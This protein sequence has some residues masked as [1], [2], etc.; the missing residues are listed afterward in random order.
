MPLNRLYVSIQDVGRCVRRYFVLV[1][2]EHQIE[3]INN[4]KKNQLYITQT[5]QFHNC[6]LKLRNRLF[7]CALYLITK[8]SC[9]RSYY[10]FR[11]VTYNEKLTVLSVYSVVSR[12][13]DMVPISPVRYRSIAVRFK[14]TLII[15]WNLLGNVIFYIFALRVKFLYLL[16]KKNSKNVTTNEIGTVK[17]ICLWS[18]VR[19]VIINI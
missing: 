1:H 3:L 4:K 2:R 5:A 14:F 16:Q 19:L 6:R 8:L 10:Q 17:I 18:T 15:C 7:C 9:L 12:T 13:V 11:R